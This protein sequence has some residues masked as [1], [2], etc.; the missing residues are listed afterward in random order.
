MIPH[1]QKL[2]TVVDFHNSSSL[3]IE[4]PL[5]NRG[6][7]DVRSLSQGRAETRGESTAE[8]D[9]AGEKSSIWEDS[10]FPGGR[11]VMHNRRI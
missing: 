5:E 10:A 3:A 8:V 1:H 7:D 4:T 11:C 2:L 6:R 9:A